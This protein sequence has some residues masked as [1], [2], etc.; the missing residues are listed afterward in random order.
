MSGPKG[1]G[2]GSDP[3][4]KAGVCSVCLR[5][6]AGYGW[7]KTLVGVTQEVQRLPI[8][9][10]NPGCSRLKSPQTRH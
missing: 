5:L 4:S 9:G 10:S 3:V 1:P 8:G 7:R 6:G 2:L